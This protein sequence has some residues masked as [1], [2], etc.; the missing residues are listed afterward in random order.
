MDLPNT[1]Q[2]LLRTEPLEFLHWSIEKLHNYIHKDIYTGYIPSILRSNAR[3]PIAQLVRAS[4]QHSEDQMS[5]GWISSYFLLQTHSCYDL[6]NNCTQYASQTQLTVF[7]CS[8]CKHSTEWTY[9]SNSL[10]CNDKGVCT[11]WPQ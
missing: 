5:P 9:T 4:D 2:M 7:R 1:V 11:K 6:P 8:N 3:D 10:C